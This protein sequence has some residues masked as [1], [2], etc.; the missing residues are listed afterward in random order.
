MS[1]G[2]EQVSKIFLSCSREALVDALRKLPEKM[3]DH[4]WEH[5]L[6]MGFTYTPTPL[7]DEKELDGMSCYPPNTSKQRDKH[8]SSCIKGTGDE[9]AMAAISEKNGL[10]NY[11]DV[12]TRSKIPFDPPFINNVDEELVNTSEESVMRQFPLLDALSKPVQSATT[13][14]TTTTAA[15]V[16][17]PP[18]S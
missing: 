2:I 6:T 9:T 13:T 14:Q 4:S 18:P 3:K 16:T 8:E 1:I 7:L 12:D 15:E 10:Y 17:P 5:S 11:L